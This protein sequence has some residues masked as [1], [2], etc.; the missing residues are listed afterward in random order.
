MD[1]LNGILEKFFQKMGSKP[2][3]SK[4]MASQLIKRAEQIARSEEISQDEAL[5]Q[6]LQKIMDHQS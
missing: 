4:V 6:L 1:S 2:K 3:Q 5:K